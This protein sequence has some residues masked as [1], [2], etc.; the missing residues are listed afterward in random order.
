MK[1]NGEWEKVKSKFGKEEMTLS[2]FATFIAHEKGIGTLSYKAVNKYLAKICKMS[3]N[4]LTLK[5]FQSNN[6]TGKL[7]GKGIY[8][9]KPEYHGI[10]AT[11]IC[12]DFFDKRKRDN[13]IENI[14]ETREQIYKNFDKYLDEDDL[15]TCKNNS[16]YLNMR[17]EKGLQGLIEYQ[18]RNALIDLYGIDSSKRHM[19]MSEFLNQ[20]VQFRKLIHINCGIN[21]RK[22]KYTI[23][24][25]L[26][27]LLE[28]KV[29]GIDYK[30]MFNPRRLSYEANKFMIMDS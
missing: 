29:H 11:L 20:L 18:L 30:A 8:K 4:K 17:I 14:E 27:H 21:K 16:P 26:I 1:V 13:K 10:L 2:E 7:K 12:S 5:D 23:E 28:M 24:N 9:L 6:N 3:K 22:D 25:F 15:K 19:Y